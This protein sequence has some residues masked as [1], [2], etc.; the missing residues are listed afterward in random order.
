MVDSGITVT[1][2]PGATTIQLRSC[3]SSLG[4]VTKLWNM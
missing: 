3:D 2:P 1:E 4:I